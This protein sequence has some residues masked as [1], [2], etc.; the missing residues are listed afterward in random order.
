MVFCHV[1][2]ARRAGERAARLKAVRRHRARLLR[3]LPHLR[4]LPSSQRQALHRR[5]SRRNQR[6][7]LKGDERSRYYNHSTFADLLITGVVGLRPRADDIVE[8]HPLLP[9]GTWDWFCLDGVSYHGHQLTVL[10]DASG[11]RY[12]R[13]AG[14]KVFVDGKLIAQSQRLERVTGR[15]NPGKEQNAT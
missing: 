9:D 3:C 7:G 1:A 5:V 10:W 4:A 15:L 13:G 8:I 12:G 14:L 6:T 2:N 11:K